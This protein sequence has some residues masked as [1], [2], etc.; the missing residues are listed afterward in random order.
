M[1]ML[2][3]LCVTASNY[4]AKS[5]RTSNVQYFSVVLDR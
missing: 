5:E 2:V 1:E 4:D 3:K